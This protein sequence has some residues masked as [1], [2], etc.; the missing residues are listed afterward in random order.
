MGSLIG[1]DLL[2]EYISGLKYYQS[3]S[4]YRLQLI[5]VNLLQSCHR[6]DMSPLD[7]SNLCNWEEWRASIRI[8]KAAVSMLVISTVYITFILP[9]L[10]IPNLAVTSVLY[11]LSK[12]R[13]RDLRVRGKVNLLMGTR[14]SHLSGAVRS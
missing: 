1:A 3:H 9:P 13:E 10:C 11:V 5:Q 14:R 6:L 2:R 8:E 7:A 4:L 12:E